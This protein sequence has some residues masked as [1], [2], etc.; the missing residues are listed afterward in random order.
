MIPINAS[1]VSDAPALLQE[2]SG[3]RVGRVRY[4]CLKEAAGGEAFM[5]IEWCWGAMPTYRYK[6]GQVPRSPFLLASFCVDYATQAKF[7]PAYN[8]LLIT[9]G[10]MPCPGSGHR[11]E[12][13]VFRGDRVQP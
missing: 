10:S 8:D 12:Q 1:A 7:P 2:G 6:P 4:S 11:Q 5:Q 9:V 3:S 13:W